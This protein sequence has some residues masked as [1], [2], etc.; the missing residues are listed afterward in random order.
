SERS[1]VR[2]RTAVSAACRDTRRCAR[3]RCP[4]RPARRSRGVEAPLWGL[5]C[6]SAVTA[7]EREKYEFTLPAQGAR[8]GAL[9]DAGAI[10]AHY[11]RN[12]QAPATGTRLLQVV[13]L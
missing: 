6:V 1:P 5:R 13:H 12:A 4:S 11:E 9:A 10:F 7:Y 8:V 3:R 2:R